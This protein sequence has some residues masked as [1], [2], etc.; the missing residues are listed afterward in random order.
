ML[1]FPPAGILGDSLSLGV[2][3]LPYH[4]INS[5][6]VIHNLSACPFLT[7]QLHQ[8]NESFGI[9]AASERSNV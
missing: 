5:A 2:I 9:F 8:L 6:F 1:L 4:R 7:T 3:R